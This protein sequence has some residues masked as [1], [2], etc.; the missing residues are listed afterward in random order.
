MPTKAR[1]A[2]TTTTVRIHDNRG[3]PALR[4]RRGTGLLVRFL[5]SWLSCSHCQPAANLTRP[6]GVSRR[7][8]VPRGPDRLPAQPHA[9]RSRLSFGLRATAVSLPL[10]LYAAFGALGSVRSV[11]RSSWSRSKSISVRWD[12][13]GDPSHP[14][15]GVPGTGGRRCDSGHAGYTLAGNNLANFGFFFGWNY[16]SANGIACVAIAFALRRRWTP[17]A[18]TM[19]ALVRCTS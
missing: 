18:I 4:D 17:A 15:L 19:S 10:R 2:R 9:G 12:R 14:A 1:W 11:R 5:H 8:S 3:C 7:R 16:G 13:L 6:V